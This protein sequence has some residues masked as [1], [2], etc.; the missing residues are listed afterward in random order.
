MPSLIVS[1]GSNFY[2]VFQVVD[3]ITI[4]RDDQNDI[5]LD[6][7]GVSRVHAV[8][9]RTKSACLLEDKNSTNGIFI[10]EEKVERASLAY[11]SSF[12]IV[13]Y[14]FTY[15]AEPHAD[16]PSAGFPGQ[17]AQFDTSQFNLDETVWLTQSIQPKQRLQHKIT[18]TLQLMIDIFSGRKN[19][20]MGALIME[21]FMQITGAQRGIVAL[22][23][24][25]GKLSFAHMRGFPNGIKSETIIRTILEKVLQ[26]GIFIYNK[27]AIEQDDSQSVH[28]LQFKSVLCVPL[29]SGQRVI[30][31]IYLDHPFH[32]GSFTPEDKDL[33]I[34]AV[35]HLADVFIGAEQDSPYLRREDERLAEELRG[36]SI[37]ARSRKTLKVFRDAKTIARY[38]VS[39]LIYGETGT[40]KEMIARYIHSQSRRKGD[41]IARNCSAIA[42]SMFESEL[43]GHEKGAFTGATARKPGIF[44]LA[45]KGTIFLDEIGDMPEP[46][47]AKLLRAL[48]EQEIWRVG[49]NAPVK[50]DVRVVAATHKDI[51][52]DRPKH[53]F[54]D[55]LYYRL[56]NVEITAPALRERPE[57]IAPL[58]VYI[59][60]SMAQEHGL[61][62]AV[63]RLCQCA[64]PAGGVPLARQYPRV[65]Q[66]A[67]PGVPQNRRQHHRTPPSE[68]TAGHFFTGR[69][70]L[71]AQPV[72]NGTGRA[73]SH[74]PGSGTHGREQIRCRKNPGY[75]PQPFE[76]P[77]EKTRSRSCPVI[78]NAAAERLLH[79]NAASHIFFFFK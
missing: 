2:K 50:I 3:T 43:F 63:D 18:R 57:D 40:G 21:A 7:P 47:Q 30:G 33:L 51:K 60:Q 1:R 12:S 70:T 35:A 53:N 46:M 55:D 34:A 48:Q 37:I 8:L 26:E 23:N 68:R 38:N 20:D 49:G 39:V 32:A 13:D 79:F 52:N 65:A 16:I 11:G 42:P 73:R 58:C 78:Q 31:C 74:Q 27:Y 24:D 75:R 62:D 71:P 9:K 4:G 69:S 41:F 66:C 15:V 5:V 14:L 6:S 22:K 56:A 44:E 54:R 76:P 72:D 17:T 67:D 19:A 45:E 77:T 10:G 61:S 28:D 64:A 36:H 25:A 29:I 59:L